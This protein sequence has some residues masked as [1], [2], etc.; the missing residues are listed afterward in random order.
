MV[1]NRTENS[2]SNRLLTEVHNRMTYWK[3]AVCRLTQH[4]WAESKQQFCMTLKIFLW[5]VDDFQVIIRSFLNPDINAIKIKRYNILLINYRVSTTDSEF[6]SWALCLHRQVRYIYGG[7]FQLSQ[8]CELVLLACL[9][10]GKQNQ[11]HNTVPLS[12]S[13]D[14]WRSI[15]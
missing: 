9:S 13:K 4:F 6:P 3:V 15:R 2:E 11:K 10:L 14:F 12:L 8:E 7:M 1:N 5:T